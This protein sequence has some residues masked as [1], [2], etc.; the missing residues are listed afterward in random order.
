MNIYEN[1][2][3]NRSHNT[4]DLEHQYTVLR[5]QLYQE[6]IKQIEQ[7]LTDLRNGRSQEFLEPLKQLSDAM[8]ERIHVAGILRKYRMENVNN[9]FCAEEQG[10][11]QN[12]EVC[13]HLYTFLLLIREKLKKKTI[14]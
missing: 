3:S 5:E 6:R 13:L 10:A 12:F 7:H 9:K 11:H 2:V 4:G 1:N 8:D 14:Q